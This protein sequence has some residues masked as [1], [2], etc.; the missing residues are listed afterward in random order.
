M[1]QDDPPAEVQEWLDGVLAGLALHDGRVEWP[2]PRRQA[3]LETVQELSAAHAQE[4]VLRLLAVAL[5]LQQGA[6]NDADDV[7]LA[8]MQLVV[9]VASPEAVEAV[10]AGVEPS[11]AAREF[12]GSSAPNLQPLKRDAKAGKSPL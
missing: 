11:R 12:L 10:I 2:H 3:A 7:C 9:E 5:R 8:M 4:A 1:A 6:G